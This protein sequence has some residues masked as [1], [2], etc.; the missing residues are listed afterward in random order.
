[1]GNGWMRW[2]RCGGLFLGG[3]WHSGRWRGVSS[4]GVG[5]RLNVP[6]Q[7]Q[8]VAAKAVIQLHAQFGELEEL[9]SNAMQPPE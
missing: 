7:F 9:L 4:R 8:Q 1:M 2:D 5:Q 6:L 3:N